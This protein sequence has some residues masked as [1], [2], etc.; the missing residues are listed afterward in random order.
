M[1]KGEFK[2]EHL[3]R[4][5]VMFSFYSDQIAALKKLAEYYEVAESYVVASLIE[6]EHIRV[7]KIGAKDEQKT[8]AKI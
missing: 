1:K 4:K 5:R 8:R 6:K 2:P 3:K 7:I